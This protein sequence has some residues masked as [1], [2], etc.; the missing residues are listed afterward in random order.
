MSDISKDVLY[1]IAFSAILAIGIGLTYA[2]K[3]AETKPI[4]NANASIE[5]LH[6]KSNINNNSAKTNTYAGA[7]K[8]AKNSH[9]TKNFRSFGMPEPFAEQVPFEFSPSSW[10]QMMNNMMNTM[11]MTQMMHQMAAMPT[12]MMNPSI[13][14]NP[15]NGLPHGAATPSQQPMSP[16]DYKKW[17]EAQQQKLQPSTK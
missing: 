3:S 2:N 8:S 14:M 15:H 13:W 16:K 11:Q 7:T 5:R 6:N 12:Q 9:P 10:M 1:F 4:T 17:Y